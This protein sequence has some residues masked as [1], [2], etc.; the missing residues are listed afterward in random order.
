MSDSL[1]SEINKW[2]KEHI[3]ELADI[4]RYAEL[5]DCLDIMDSVIELIGGHFSVQKMVIYA[6]KDVGFI[7]QDYCYQHMMEEFSTIECGNVCN[8]YVIHWLPVIEERYVIDLNDPKEI[9][10]DTNPAKFVFNIDEYIEKL[11]SLNEG[12]NLVFK[13]K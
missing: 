12:K 10:E 13:L 11:T 4:K 1:F 3:E 6:G 5:G 9:T 7:N 8:E 2:S